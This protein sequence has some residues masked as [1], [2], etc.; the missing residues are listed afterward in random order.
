MFQMRDASAPSPQVRVGSLVKASLGGER[1]WLH[2]RSVDEDGSLR[3][4]VG[5]DLFSAALRCGDEVELHHSHV[6]ETADDADYCEFQRLVAALGSQREAAIA[7]HLARA[8]KGL[9]K[10]DPNARWILPAR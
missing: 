2:V 1:F 9:S 8:A 10:P 4:S 5:N 6:L 3:A 7:W